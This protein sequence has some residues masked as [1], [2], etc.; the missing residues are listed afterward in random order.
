MH[1]TRNKDRAETTKDLIRTEVK[2]VIIRQII[3]YGM[4]E[5]KEI[6]QAIV[7]ATKNEE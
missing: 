7:N 3:K 5:L 1:R 6:W 2:R 4:E